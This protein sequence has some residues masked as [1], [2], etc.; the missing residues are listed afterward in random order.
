MNKVFPASRA[1]AQ[2]RLLIY[3]LFSQKISEATES[4]LKVEPSLWDKVL[5][6]LEKALRDNNEKTQDKSILTEAFSAID[7]TTKKSLER[8]LTKLTGQSLWFGIPATNLLESFLTEHCQLINSVRGEHL[9]KIHSLIIRGMRE[10]KLKRD[11]AKDI[12]RYTRQSKKRAML[13]ARN[14][15]LQYSGALTKHHQTNAGIKSYR[16]QTSHDERVRDSHRVFNGKICSWDSAGPHPRSEIN[17]R[18]DAI[19]ILLR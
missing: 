10:G 15:P 9:D 11:M 4:L 6:M 19:P 2:A 12:L 17:C 16:W 1:S 7:K 5:L 3:R 18:C 13:I 8:Q 14:A